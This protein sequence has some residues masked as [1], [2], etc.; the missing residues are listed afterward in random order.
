VTALIVLAASSAWAADE[1]PF[2]G[3]YGGVDYSRQ[4]IVGGS[5]VNGVDILQH[6][7]RRAIDFFGGTRYQFHFGLVF[8]AE[9]GYGLTDGDLRL[10]DPA[11]QL[12]IDYAN[13]SQWFYGLQIG[14]AFGPRR[15]WMAFAYLSEVSRD[16][17][18]TIQTRGQTF[19]QS[20]EQGMLRYGG[21]LEWR[22]AG[23]LGLRAS[24]GSAR[25]DFGGRRTNID[26]DDELELS[27]GLIVQIWP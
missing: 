12:A 17:D 13:D 11:S 2:R 1:R 20:D 5:L 10:S 22:L 26:V 6:D 9:A 21:G 7:T 15:S 3:L 24:L 16:F 19:R 18:V 27:V 4:N 23:P 14:W 8:G 25:A